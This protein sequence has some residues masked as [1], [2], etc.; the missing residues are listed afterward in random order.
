MAP[1]VLHNRRFNDVCVLY[2]KG[3]F[4]VC[5][6]IVATFYFFVENILKMIYCLSDNFR[7]DIF[8]ALLFTFY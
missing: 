3:F 8:F 7:T 1:L 6:Q 5:L 2:R 4:A